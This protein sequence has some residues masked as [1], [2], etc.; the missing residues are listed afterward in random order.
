[1]PYMFGATELLMP[2]MLVVENKI[3]N[4]IKS[5]VFGSI[6]TQ[7]IFFILLNLPDQLQQHIVLLDHQCSVF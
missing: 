6:C 3:L 5:S 2:P 1:M 4:K 7:V